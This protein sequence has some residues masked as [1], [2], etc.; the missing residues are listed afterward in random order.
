MS[1]AMTKILCGRKIS[2]MQKMSHTHTDIKL[3]VRKF[4]QA[5][6]GTS[7]KEQL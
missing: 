5:V 1:I 4:R 3:A 7:S 2:E 6:T